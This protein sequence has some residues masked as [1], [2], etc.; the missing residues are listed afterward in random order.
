MDACNRHSKLN[1][2]VAP[3]LFLEFHGSEQALAEQVQRTGVLGCCGRGGAGPG[4]PQSRAWCQPPAPDRGDHPAQRRLSLLL[5]QGGGGPQPALG[6]AAQCLVYAALA[7][8]PGCKVSGLGWTREPF[9]SLLPYCPGQQAEAPA[10]RT[11]KSSGGS[12]CPEPGPG[13][14]DQGGAVWTQ[15]AGFL[16]EEVV[17][18]KGRLGS[19]CWGACTVAGVGSRMRALGA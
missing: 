8:R 12:P 17:K 5:G 14:R 11:A 6:S 4:L 16:E 15:K 1:C 2:C 9:L 3:T 10:G 19:R 7:L 18:R 13:C